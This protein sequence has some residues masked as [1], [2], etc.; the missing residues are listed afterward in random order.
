MPPALD[1]IIADLKGSDRQERIDL[2]LD[3]AKSLPPLP[4]RLVAHKDA[5]HRV[6]ECQS[7]VYLFVELEGD[8]VSLHADAP[9]E[10][11]TVRGFVSLLVEGLNGATV[12]EVLQVPGDVVDRS[13]LGEIL[14]MLRVRGLSG[15]LRRLKAEVTRT[16]IDRAGAVPG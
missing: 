3:F 1:A 7:P 4:E 5:S 15:V 8:R 9:I 12:E 2:L 11:P 14:G 13:G 10:A 16:A 6:E